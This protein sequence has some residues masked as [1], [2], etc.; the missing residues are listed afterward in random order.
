MASKQKRQHL[1][2]VYDK[3]ELEVKYAIAELKKL[4]RAE[5]FRIFRDSALSK[6]E[7]VNQCIAKGVENAAA[8][9]VVASEGIQSSRTA[10]KIL[11][12]ADQRRTLIVE[13]DG[14]TIFQASG[15]LGVILAAVKHCTHDYNDVLETLTGAGV[16]MD[17]IKHE[18]E[19]ET[20]DVQADDQDEETLY[21][22]GSAAGTI[23]AF[24]IY[25]SERYDMSFEVS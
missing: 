22:G 18:E 20:K 14:I 17:Q 4:L 1:F 24:Y 25:G 2:F 16:R 7:L 9:L 6:P 3:K 8:I 19:V 5:K 23:E 11:N 12:Y 15:W 13:I 10:S 21:Y